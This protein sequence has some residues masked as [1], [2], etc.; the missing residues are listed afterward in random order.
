MD[1]S[2]SEAREKQ[3][4]KLITGHWLGLHKSFCLILCFTPFKFSKYV[5]FM[6]FG[7]SLPEFYLF[8]V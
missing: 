3:R 6:S 4:I 1:N 5:H 7:R 8:Y 2:L